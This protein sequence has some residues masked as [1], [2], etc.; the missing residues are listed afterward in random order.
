MSKSNYLTPHE[1]RFE[2]W[3]KDNMPYL[4]KLWDF[5]EARYE[6]ELVDNFLG[7]CSSGEALMCCFAIQVWTGGGN[8]EY[9]FN[10]FRAMRVLGDKEIEIIQKWVAEPWCC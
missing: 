1:E 4:L 9:E 7:V 5:T 10:L 6:K 3:L 8:T 2:Y